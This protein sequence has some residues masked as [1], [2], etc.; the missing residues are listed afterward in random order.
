MN[1]G[2]SLQVTTASLVNS[3]F[4]SLCNSLHLNVHNVIVRAFTTHSIA[5]RKGVTQNDPLYIT[6]TT[7]DKNR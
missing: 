6:V 7:S 5:F 4:N 3:P 2:C 1:G